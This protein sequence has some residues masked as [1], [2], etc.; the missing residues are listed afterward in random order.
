MVAHALNPSPLGRQEWV[1]KTSPLKMG[2]ATEVSEEARAV[3][4]PITLHLELAE[5]VFIIPSNL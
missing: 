4:V 1:D 3:S 5:A 2:T